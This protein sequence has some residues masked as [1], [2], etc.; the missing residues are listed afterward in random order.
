MF[1]YKVHNKIIS[2][3]R[4]VLMSVYLPTRAK[5]RG[6]VRIILQEVPMKAMND[7]GMKCEMSPLYILPDPDSTTPP[8]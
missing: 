5:K 7:E 2:W 4:D 1:I 3:D 8:R 6:I